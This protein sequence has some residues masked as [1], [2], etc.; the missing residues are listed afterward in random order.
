MMGRQN[1]AW[2]IVWHM[3]KQEAGPILLVEHPGAGVFRAG[4]RLFLAGYHDFPPREGFP[5][6]LP[7]RTARCP[8]RMAGTLFSTMRTFS[9][10]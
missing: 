7:E 1:G 3:Q 6:V 10:A 2:T 8:R 9:P 5:N 4:L